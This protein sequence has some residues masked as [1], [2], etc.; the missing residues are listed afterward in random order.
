MLILWD[1]GDRKALIIVRIAS[2]FITGQQSDD[3]FY[4]ID[5]VENQIGWCSN[6]RCATRG[7]DLEL[8]VE[9]FLASVFSSGNN[10]Y[11]WWLLQG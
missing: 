4:L 5:R 10:S 1:F 6:L 8:F 3:H 7:C 2:G 11:L 9:S